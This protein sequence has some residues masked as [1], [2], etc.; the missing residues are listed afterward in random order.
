MNLEIRS[1]TSTEY[2]KQGLALLNEIPDPPTTIYYQGL[3]PQSDITLLSVVGS[4]LYSSYGKQVIDYLIGGLR[5]YPVGIVSGLA[6]GIDTL[7]HEAALR[8]NLYTLA[9]PGSGLSPSVLY[10][11]SNL[12]LATTILESGGGLL[13]EFPPDL[14]AAV[15]T[16]PKRNRIMAGLT[17]ATLLIEAGERSGTLITARLAT[18]FNRELLV[19]PGNIFARNSRGIHQFLKLGATPI[20]ETSDILDVLHISHTNENNMH[21]RQQTLPLSVSEEKILSI[22]IEPVSP[23]ELIRSCGLPIEEANAL[24][25]YMEIKG[26]IKN[27]HGMIQAII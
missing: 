21:N 24:L 23:D 7:A 20:T 5:G 8:N 25:T 4:R 22:L 14:R 12:R 1:L 11:R 18:D 15:W 13:S 17:S 3:L 6:K 2:S 26:L 10:P 9:I 19:V 27:E 16:F